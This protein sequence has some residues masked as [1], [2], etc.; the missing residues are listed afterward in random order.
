LNK[1]SNLLK[2]NF[3]LIALVLTFFVVMVLA[4][5]PNSPTLN[6]PADGSTGNPTTVT[7]NVT[8]TE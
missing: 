1:S 7:L 3:L 4:V 6:S 5:A 2:L 8:V